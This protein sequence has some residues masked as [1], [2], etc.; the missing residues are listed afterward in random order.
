M[1]LSILKLSVPCEQHHMCVYIYTHT[2]ICI[3]T[4]V[5]TDAET[6]ALILWPP[7]VE[8]HWKKNP[9]AGKD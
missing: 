1:V 8:S 2:Y 7:D 9:D 5:R 3:Y 4:Y 6:E